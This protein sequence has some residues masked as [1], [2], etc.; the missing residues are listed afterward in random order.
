[1]IKKKCEDVVQ[2]FG[3]RLVKIENNNFWIV[4]GFLHSLVKHSLR[5]LYYQ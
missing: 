4:K 3:C 5:N 1:M 2:S